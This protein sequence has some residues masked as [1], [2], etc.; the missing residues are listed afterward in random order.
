MMAG[1]RVEMVMLAWRGSSGHFTLD[2]VAQPT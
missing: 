1:G 2:L